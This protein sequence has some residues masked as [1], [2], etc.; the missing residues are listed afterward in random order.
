VDTDWPVAGVPTFLWSMSEIAVRVALGGGAPRIH[1]S[2]EAR[3][4][5]AAATYELAGNKV[6]SEVAFPLLPVVD[7]FVEPDWSIVC[8]GGR[9]RSVGRWY[10]Q[11]CFR[12]GRKWLSFG[13]SG[14]DYILRFPG[15]I[16]FRVSRPDRR[17]VC[18]AARSIP[19]ET[20]RHL[21]LNQVLPL[22]FGTERLV[23][24]ASAVRGPRGVWGFAGAG[25]AGKSTLAAAL[26]A[27]GYPLVSDDA[28]LLDREAGWLAR[29]GYPSLRLWPD[30][31]MAT[32]GRTAPSRRAAPHTRKQR[33]DA[34]GLLPIVGTNS[35]IS[36][37]AMLDRRGH[38]RDTVRV[39]RLPMREAALAVLSVAFQIDIED[40]ALLRR[41][42]DD[43]AALVE[44]V[45]VYRLSFASR[46]DRVATTA[47]ALVDAL[48]PLS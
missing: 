36:A 20:W 13:R 45:P 6:R 43:A 37:V 4:P 40:G 21:L 42:V 23:L 46:L 12:D 24:H 29:P 14:A 15:R 26:A 11:W 2:P 38:A 9:E 25:G 47:D 1:A 34:A 22:V 32:L 28:L 27:R 3:P 10:H 17:I 7:G 31:V 16:V 19:S 33:V 8:G 44:R 18:E 48:A 41:T 5:L 30:S 35:P 39:E